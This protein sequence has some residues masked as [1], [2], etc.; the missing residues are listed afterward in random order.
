[1]TTE[2]FHHCLLIFSLLVSAF[3]YIDTY[4]LPLKTEQEVVLDF[5]HF[6]Q[7]IRRSTNHTYLIKTTKKEIDVTQLAYNSTSINDTIILVSSKLTNSIQKITI[8]K[9]GYLSTFLVGFV[10]ARMGSIF[11][12]VLIIC[13]V[14][15][16]FF[17]K[18]INYQEGKN[19]FTYMIFISSL[20]LI[21][22]YLGFF[23][24]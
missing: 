13:I 5:E 12:P 19:N 17:Y 1:M 2:K 7:R 4:L 22:Y 3:L 15:F 14:G 11:T 21:S 6:S 8:K 18:K 20:C 10:N 24:S 16:L 9:N 23:F